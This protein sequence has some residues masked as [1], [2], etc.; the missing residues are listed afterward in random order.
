[1]KEKQWKEIFNKY[2]VLNNKNKNVIAPVVDIISW[3][4]MKCIHVLNKKKYR[5]IQTQSIR[6][7]I[8]FS[9]LFKALQSNRF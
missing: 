5:G 4:E 3:F 7:Q 9:I 2:K 8:C 1:M 6:N